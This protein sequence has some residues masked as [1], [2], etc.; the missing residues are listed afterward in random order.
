VARHLALD[1]DCQ[2][3][4]IVAGTVRAGKLRI[5]QAA[6]WQ[7]EQSPN[8]AKADALGRHLRERLRSAG[9]L[10]APVL[11]CVGRD[12][13]ILREVR[14]PSVAAAEEPAVVRFQVLKELSDLAHEV[15]IDYTPLG[16]VG[17]GEERRALV[18]TVR[19]ELLS[20]YQTLCRAAG[21][22][23]LAL[24][25]RPFGTLACLRESLKGSNPYPEG[26]NRAQA[27]LALLTATDRWSEF[28]LVRGD[29][30]LVARS[31]PAG[32]GLAAEVRR[33]IVVY[34]AQSPRH[35]VSAL[36][37]AGNGE[38][39]SLQECLQQSLEIPVRSFD[40][41]AGAE[42]VVQPGQN[43]GAFAGAVGLLSAQA[44]GSRLPI[45]FAAPKEPEV[46][47]DPNKRR[48]ALAAGMA[49]LVL[50]GVVSYC[51]SDLASLDRQINDLTTERTNLDATQMPLVE[52]KEE[53][54]KELAEWTRGKVSW[55]D[56]IY[57]VTALIPNLRTLQVSEFE[58][59]LLPA[60]K[61]KPIAKMTLKLLTTNTDGP[62]DAFINA[63][64]ADTGH[65]PNAPVPSHEKPKE[66][67]FSREFTAEIHVEKQ[68]SGQFDHYL[69]APSDL[70]ATRGNRKRPPLNKTILTSHPGKASGIA[71]PQKGTMV[72][73]LTP[74]TPDAGSKIPVRTGV[75]LP[76]PP[77]QPGAMPP[78]GTPG[79]EIYEELRK[80][81]PQPHA[82][83]E[84]IRTRQE[85]PY[86]MRESSGST[87][88]LAPSVEKGKKQ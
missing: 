45:N 48:L 18:L 20:A 72:K 87:P 46:S 67:G 5:E 43:R 77:S 28:C 64:A 26:D 14:Y 24:T 3:L 70:Q 59:A 75:V 56:E 61:D 58:G 40:P 16:E 36:Y 8:I 50:V 52:E 79:A 37:L 76:N 6:V 35:T 54:L 66:S 10:P 38:N 27:A 62:I 23:L 39:G 44:D 55:L 78:P 13:V 25:P 4:R 88:A 2:R 80:A 19:R 29:T 51:Y 71:T 49:A 63:L 74:A 69:P 31:L 82:F 11:A 65:V 1:W 53:H 15:V 17:P 47:R 84:T 73:Y 22:K 12:R 57:S 83:P 33:N 30:L 85:K 9:I 34:S 60:A 42:G 68:H 86:Q 21:L 81:F 41:F 7:E 32:P